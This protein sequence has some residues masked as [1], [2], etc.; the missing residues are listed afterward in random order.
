MTAAVKGPLVL[1][2]HAAAPDCVV[3]IASSAGGLAALQQLLAALP[4][5]FPAA[6]V[7]VQHLSP[8]HPSV[9]ARLLQRHAALRVQE[10]GQDDPLRAGTVYVAPPNR[11]LLIR[12][13]ATLALSE[14]PPVNFLR[15]AADVLFTSAAGSYKD[16]AF[17]VVLT[18]TGS[19][20][21]AGVRAV[22]DAGGSAIAQDQ[23]TAEFFGM[24]G[25]AI[26]TGAVDRVL[27]LGAIAGALEE[28]VRKGCSP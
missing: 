6:I 23:A 12:P 26:A 25:A 8:T 22:K 15:P 20:G 17:A 14:S 3:V 28:L 5:E 7:V 13:D 18:G 16:R 27:P 1:R 19:D 10:A 2:K 21:A 11:H 9:M 24:P 4:A